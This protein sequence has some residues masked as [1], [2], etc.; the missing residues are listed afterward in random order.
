MFHAGL[1]PQWDLDTAT[2]CAGELEAALRSERSGELFRRMYGNEPA[3]WTESLEGY[4]RLRFITNCLTRLRVCRDDG[5]LELG[6]KGPP[7][8]IPD[9]MHPWFRVPGRRTAGQRMVCGHWSA[10]GYHEEGGV[11]AIDTGCVWGGKLTGQRIDVR[12]RPVSIP[13][14]S[15]GVPIEYD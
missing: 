12:S 5:H 2:R 8:R 1:P 6:F 10:L 11:L 15:G 7:V 14:L 9:G 4:D 3:I 13:S